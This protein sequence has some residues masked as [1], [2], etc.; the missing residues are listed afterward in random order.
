M[1]K[2]SYFTKKKVRIGNY[3][4]VFEEANSQAYL[5]ALKDGEQYEFIMEITAFDKND[6]SVASYER[7][8]ETANP[9]VIERFIDKFCQDAK[10]RAKFQYD[11]EPIDAVLEKNESLIHPKCAKMIADLNKKDGESTRFRDFV[12]LRTYGQ[13]KISRMKFDVLKD[14]LPEEEIA[15]LKENYGDDNTLKILRWIKRGL[16]VDHAIHKVRV[17]MEVAQNAR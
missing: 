1:L 3:E 2:K 16:K 12:A 9:S 5:Y 8:W 6:V 15:E 13:D 11:G 17:D 4:F 7:T 10:F 14:L